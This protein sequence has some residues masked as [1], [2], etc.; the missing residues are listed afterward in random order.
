MANFSDY[1]SNAGGQTAGN[2]AGRVE[3]EQNGYWPLSRLKRAYLDYVGSKR[4]E[5]LEQQDARRY[6][7]SSQWT[8]A[9]IKEFNRRKQP[10]VTHNRISPKIN[11]IVGLIEK[12]RQAPKAYPRTPKEEAGAD[13]ATAVVRYVVDEQQFKTLSPFCGQDAA[14]DG[15]S[16]IEMVLETGDQGDPEI[17]L[18]KVE[19]DDFF[20]DPRSYSLDFADCRYMGVAKWLDL[21]MAVEMFPDKETEIRDSLESG[22]DL[23]TNSDRENRWYISDGDIKRVRIIDHW[24][25]MRGEWCYCV[26]TGSVK[27]SEGKSYFTDQKGKSFCKFVMFSANVDQDGDRYGFVRQFKSLQDEINQRRSKSL[28]ILNSRRILAEDGAFDDIEKTRLEAVRPDGVIIHNKGFEASFDD[29]IKMQE[30]EAQLKFLQEAKE[31]LDSYGPTLSL[32]GDI[33]ANLSGRAIS[34]QQQAGIA[35]LGPFMVSYRAWKLRVY[36]AIWNAVRQH[37]KA[38]RWI[39]VTDDENSV[40]FVGLN[41]IG[42]NPMTGMPTMVNQ[43]SA[44]DVDI[45]MEE[46]PDTINM[47]ADT[48]EAL[49]ALAQNGAEIPPAILLELAPG[50]DATTRKRLIDKMSQPDPMQEMAKQLELAQVKGKIDD[51]AA[52]TGLKKAQTIDTLRGEQGGQQGPEEHPV[53]TQANVMNTMADTDLKRAQALATA[54]KPSQEEEKMR[55]DQ[56]KHA[57]DQALQAHESERERQ[58]KAEDSERNRQLKAHDASHKVNSDQAKSSREEEL[59]KFDM[60]ER[61]MRLRMEWDQ[62]EHQKKM[63]ERDTGEMVETRKSKAVAKKKTEDG[64]ATAIQA[65]A[66]SSTRSADAIVKATGAL[67][68]SAKEMGRS[69]DVMAKAATAPKRVVRDK[70]GRVSHVEAG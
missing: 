26:Y 37:W 20:Y 19:G 17:A 18:L 55:A 15:F 34:L 10:V 32:V 62:H 61:Q 50:I 8:D 39:R 45:I 38:E 58:F 2:T 68:E 1:S 25:K 66:D 9:Q 23:T 36:R 64:L 13:L 21:E 60:Q 16:G 47:M 30:T 54:M 14:I 3:P 67:A 24:Y 22:S 4:G 7:H 11:G 6:R 40:N 49:S 33:G 41:Q 46:G 29:G 59:H 51:T 65:L 43:V 57:S 28:H 31:E 27:L 44:L 5:I 70:A 42:T 48:W 63:D 12:L 69:A 56:E 53:V 52:A 35:Q